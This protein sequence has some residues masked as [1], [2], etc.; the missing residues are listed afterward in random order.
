M[1]AIQLLER[2]VFA[3]EVPLAPEEVGYTLHIAGVYEDG[4]TRDLRAFIGVAE[5][6]DSQ[7][8]RTSAYLQAVARKAQLDFIPQERK[9]PVASGAPSIK[10]IRNAP[11]PPRKHSRNS[12]ASISMLAAI[13]H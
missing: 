4:V 11:A 10:L 9:R 8:A 1:E 5:P 6:P 13:R 7:F 3:D 12:T 2:T